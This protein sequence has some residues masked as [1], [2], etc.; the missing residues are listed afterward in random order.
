MGDD[1]LWDIEPYVTAEHL[2][3]FGGIVRAYAGVE[4]GIKLGLATLLDLPMVDLLILAEPYTSAS[5][6]HVVR[7]ITMAHQPA[8]QGSVE[9]MGFADE[10]QKASGLRNS[11]AHDRW[12][13][14]TA[15]GTI[16]PMRLNIRSGRTRYIGADPEEPEWS[17]A[18]LN[19]KRK[20]L[21][22]LYGRVLDWLTREGFPA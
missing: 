19:A 3:V 16:K 22:E 21:A 10:L 6:G 1:Q 11:V 18:D 5:L 4:G 13:A 7:S 8:T 15:P 17:L 2:Q 20:E 9:L 14:G 12:T